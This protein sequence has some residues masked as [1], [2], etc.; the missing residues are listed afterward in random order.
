MQSRNEDVLQVYCSTTAE[1]GAVVHP[2]HARKMTKRLWEL[3]RGKKWPTFY[4]ENTES[5]SGGAEDAK[6]YAFQTA[7]G[8]DFMYNT[9]KKNANKEKDKS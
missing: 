6:H 7:L 8:F 1:E 4:Y 9:L 2:G 5:G 3:G